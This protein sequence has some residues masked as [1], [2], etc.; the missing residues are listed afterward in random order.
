VV[1][2]SGGSFENLFLAVCPVID[3][4]V[5]QSVLV[6]VKVALCVTVHVFRDYRYGATAI[7]ADE[8]IGVERRPGKL[9]RRTA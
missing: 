9:A 6:A 8:G 5:H 1:L 4:L 2:T 7:L 3:D